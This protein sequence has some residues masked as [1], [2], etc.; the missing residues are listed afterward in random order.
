[1]KL[2]ANNKNLYLGLLKLLQD[3]VPCLLATVARTSGS[4]PQVPGSSA[5]IGRKGLI[6]GTIGG[7]I[8]EQQVI[9]SAL[10]RIDNKTPGYFHF[11]LHHDI[12]HQEEA[13]CG[14]EMS[15]LLDAFPEKHCSVF[16]QIHEAFGERRHGVLLTLIEE[17]PDH[18]AQIERHWYTGENINGLPFEVIQIAFQMFNKPRPG[19]FREIPISI[20]STENNRTCFLE[21][22][23]PPPQLIIAGAGHIGKALSHLGSLLDFEVTV[24]DDR[25]EFANK[26]LLPDADHVLACDFMEASEKI[27]IASDTYLVIVT[28][29]HRDDALVLKKY[30]GSDAA[31]IGMIGSRSK[32][33][34]VREKFLENNWATTAQWERVHTPIGLPI[35]SKTVQEI[36]VSIAAELIRERNNRQN[37]G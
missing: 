21:T 7:G 2:T 18:S 6:A 27:R 1:M 17:G 13:I 25:P 20:P 26:E 31:Y 5:I 8:V 33:G 37:H 19:D 11:N 23:V 3:N 14:G 36:A 28:R 29:G 30:I 4:T 9:Q 12:S 24:W 16:E 34:Q 10:S 32:I 15:V 35:G 22:V